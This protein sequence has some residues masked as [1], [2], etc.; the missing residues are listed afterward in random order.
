MSSADIASKKEVESLK[1]EIKKLK[2]APK[3]K[4]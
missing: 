4:K 3:T 1:Q 2:K